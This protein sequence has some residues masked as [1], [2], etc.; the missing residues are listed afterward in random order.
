MSADLSPYLGHP[1]ARFPHGRRFL[2]WAWNRGQT[3]I[4]QQLLTLIGDFET[5]QALGSA[6]QFLTQPATSHALRD[7]AAHPPAGYLLDLSEEVATSPPLAKPLLD[8]VTPTEGF[9][10]TLTTYYLSAQIA[11][12]PHA[13]LSPDQKLRLHRL[14]VWILVTALDALLAGHARERGLQIVCTQLRMGLDAKEVE[15]GNPQETA[16]RLKKVRWFLLRH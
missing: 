11:A 15:G 1:A 6:L 12:R 4:A 13:E 16:E 10:T 5:E 14:R 8:G 9:R 2:E 3:T 7:W